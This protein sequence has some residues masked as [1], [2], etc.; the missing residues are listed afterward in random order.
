MTSGYFDHI[1]A[2]L[3]NAAD[4]V[5]SHIWSMLSRLDSNDRAAP[6]VYTIAAE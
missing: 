5:A 4:V 1:D 2:V 6:E 3:V